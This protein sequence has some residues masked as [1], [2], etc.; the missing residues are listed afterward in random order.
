MHS[1]HSADPRHLTGHAPA[2]GR[3][4]EG[5][6]EQGVHGVTDERGRLGRP[7]GSS[8]APATADAQRSTAASAPGASRSSAIRSR[9]AASTLSAVGAPAAAGRAGSQASVADGPGGG[10]PPPVHGRPP[11]G[12]PVLRRGQPV[13]RSSPSRRGS[14]GPGW[15]AGSPS[16]RRRRPPAGTRTPGCPGTWTSSR[17]PAAPS[18]RARSGGRTRRAPARPSARAT[19]ACDALISWCGK[20]RSEPPA[21]T[22]NTSPRYAVAIAAHSTCQPG[23]PGPNREAQDGSPGRAASQT[24]GIQRVLLARPGRV[25]A[26]LGE[27]LRHGRRVQPGHRAPNSG[28]AAREKY[29]SP[30]EVVQRAAVGQQ[31]VEPLD[32]RHRL[33]RADQPGGR[34]HPQRLHVAP[35]P[36]DLPVGQLPPVLAVPLGPL[37]QRIVHVGDVLHVG[38]LVPGVQPGPDQQVPGDVGRRVADVRGVVRGDPARVQASPAARRRPRASS[39]VAVSASTV[40]APGPGRAGTFAACQVSICAGY[41]CARGPGR[42]RAGRASAGT[43]RGAAACSN[44]YASAISRGSLHGGP[45]K[46]RP[47]RQAG[48]TPPGRSLAGYPATAA[49]AE[50]WKTSWSPRT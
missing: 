23:R 45:R 2:R 18:R 4:S 21:W 35:V 32:Q 1:V 8:G 16:G 29:M 13:R 24:S 19:R 12:Q 17:R 36:G 20:I 43:S 46:D 40:P 5:D 9:T 7:A 6:A 41:L 10:Q 48:H 15:P 44:A 22:S 38:H 30:L 11:A 33:H 3:R 39:P 37:Q 42:R 14:G 26:A 28:S 31:P 49:G 34:Q 25:A 47:D 50:V 27:Q